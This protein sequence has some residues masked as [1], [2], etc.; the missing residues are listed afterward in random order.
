MGLIGYRDRG[1]HYVTRRYDLTTDIDSVY[2]QLQQFRAD[3][4]GDP[5]ESVN[6]ALHEAVSK[7]HWSES[8]GVYR[9]IFLVGDAPPHMDYQDDVPFRESMKLARARGIA[10]NTV[11]CGA[12]DQ[13]RLVWQE[14]AQLGSGQYAAIAQDG[15]M[16]ALAA[17]MDEELS[18]LNRQLAGTVI[19]YGSDARKRE[20][21]EKVS[22]ATSAPAAASADRLAYLKKAGRGV[23]AG[24]G[25]LLDAMKEGV[26]LD[27]VPEAE[28]PA[29]LQAMEPARRNAYVEQKAGERAALQSRIDAL[30][31]ERDSWTKD[32]MEKLAKSGKGD[33]FDQKVFDAIEE[34]AAAKGIT[35]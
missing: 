24:A 33:G 35:Y 21:A 31:E 12:M 1:D 19:G 6:Q 8:K 20:V 25:D 26:S 16:V 11:Q 28:L 23:L 2:A 9:V 3:G 27:D 13:T 7:L 18:L 10:V 4:G 22:N 30:T 32:E 29:E 34:Q 15:G 17:P 5:P 14:I